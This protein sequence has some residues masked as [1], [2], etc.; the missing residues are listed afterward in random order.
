MSAQACT[1]NEALLAFQQGNVLR[2]QALLAMAVKDG[3][4]RASALFAI[5]NDVVQDGDR[6]NEKTVRVLIANLDTAN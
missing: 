3:D 6:L 1:Y 2:G 5:L 4:R